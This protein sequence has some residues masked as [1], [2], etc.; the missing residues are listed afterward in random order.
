MD[1]L[2]PKFIATSQRCMVID[3]CRQCDRVTQKCYTIQR[4]ADTSFVAVVLLGNSRLP[5][6][7]I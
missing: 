7:R 6:L 4:T 1:F 5:S 3:T 2:T